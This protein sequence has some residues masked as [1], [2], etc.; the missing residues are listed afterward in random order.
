VGWGGGILAFMQLLINFDEIDIIKC[1]M[2]MKT[3]ED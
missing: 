2:R 3:E 1:N